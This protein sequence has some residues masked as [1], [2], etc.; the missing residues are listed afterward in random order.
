MRFHLLDRIDAWYPG[1][2][3]RGVKAVTR[4]DGAAPDVAAG[5]TGRVILIESLAQLASYLLGDAEAREG[6]QVLSLMIGVDRLAFQADPRPGDRL[7]LDAAV[8]ARGP[9]GARVAVAARADDQPVCEGRLT[10]AFF[11]AESP[12]QVRDFAW[13]QDHLRLLARGLAEGE[14]P[15][16]RMAPE[17]AR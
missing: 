8:L 5:W 15:G 10:F 9:E 4:T 3:A 1:E 12:A 6:R 2:R 17:E 7:V 11:A 16:G 14:P 13:T